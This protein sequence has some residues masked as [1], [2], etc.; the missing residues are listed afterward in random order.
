MLK[1][2]FAYVTRKSIK[3]LVILLVIMTMTSL[4]LFSLMIKDATTRA[5]KETFK[6]ISNSF[7]MEINRLVNPGTARGAGNVRG[8]DIVKIMKTG[9]I[10]DHLKRINCV[11]DLVDKEIITTEITKAYTDPTRA[12]RFART[13]TITGVNDSQ[14]ETKF[15]SGVF[16]LVKG[17]HLNKNDKYQILM[18]QDLAAKN[19]LKIGD[20]IKMKTNLYDAD[21]AKGANETVEVTIKGLFN[22]SNATSAGDS[23]TLYENN[24]IA[25]IHSAANIYGNSEETA[26]YQDVTFFV[27]GNK[28]LDT[29]LKQ[30]AKLDIDWQAY[31]L[32]KSSAN[33]P[34]LTKSI[35]GLYGIAKQLFTGSLVFA[36]LIVSLLLFLW[37]NG[38]KKEL[39]VYLAIGKTKLEIFTQLALELLFISLPAYI[40]SYFI[41]GHLGQSVGNKVLNNVTSSITKQFSQQASSSGLAGSAEADGFSKTLNAL[42]I[43]IN[44]NI[45]THALIFMSVVLMVALIIAS[46]N[47]LHKKPK[48]LLLDNE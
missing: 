23:Q 43:K 35:S 36:G 18:H 32:I 42:D 16:K 10:D 8:Q 5:E 24:I 1:N 28:D 33:Y 9:L 27:K 39:A 48:Q 34:A 31:N 2:A 47:I 26:T 40:G 21:N 46:F 37:L 12:K 20:K 38:R 45:V 41:S 17:Q 4:S 11:A 3:S 14:R 19:N 6:S 44:I 13:V 22:G 15:I 30:M 25:D 7:T 29:V